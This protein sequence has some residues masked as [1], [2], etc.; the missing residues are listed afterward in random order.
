MLPIR[1]LHRPA[2]LSELQKNAGT[3][4]LEVMRERLQLL[5]S[6]ES[7]QSIAG[8]DFDRWADTRLDRWLTDW[9]LRSGK[10]R[11]AKKLAQAR[12]IEVGFWFA[13]SPA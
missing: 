1:T 12:G 2:Q 6:V 11:T 7:M 4:T 13:Q 3:P 10:E 5:S 8:P 9:A